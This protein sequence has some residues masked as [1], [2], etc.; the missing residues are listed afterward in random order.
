MPIRMEKH[1]E[2]CEEYQ[3]TKRPRFVNSDPVEATEHQKSD[4]WKNHTV[5]TTR[6][7]V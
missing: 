1:L 3:T 2:N 7:E 6:D 4:Y 5:K